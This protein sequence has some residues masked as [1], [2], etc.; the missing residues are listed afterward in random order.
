[1][2]Q[3]EPDG[4]WLCRKQGEIFRES[5]NTQES[6]SA[7]FIRRFMY[8]DLAERMDEGLFQY[9]A[10]P[11]VNESVSVYGRKYGS[12][13]FSPE[14]L[15]WI[16]YV[17][18]Y[19][20]YVHEVKSKAIYRICGAREMRALYFPYHSLDPEAAVSRILEAK[21]IRPAT[22]EDEL[23]QGVRILRAIIRNKRGRE[24]GV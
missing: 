11:C 15:Y 7:V 13:C 9:C 8:S 3:M 19:W 10:D 23:E 18:R 14:E 6:S 22:P 5:L 2:R 16:G 20:S 24:R 4:L 1:M 17:Y 12:E 21:G